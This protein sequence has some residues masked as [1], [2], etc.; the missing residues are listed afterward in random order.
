MTDMHH[1]TTTQ[2]VPVTLPGMGHTYLDQ[3]MVPKVNAFIA[4]AQAHGVSLHFNSAFRTPEHQER[5]H[6]DPNAITPATHSLHS[7]GFA[8]DMNY[9]T[10][11]E[12]QR[13][14]IRTA[15]HDAGLSWGGNFHRSDPPHFYADPPIDR[16]TAIANATRQ[17]NELTGEHR[18]PA[19]EH[20]DAPIHQHN[21]LQAPPAYP[22]PATSTQASPR[23]DEAS[24]PDHALFQQAYAGV[25]KID[26]ERGRASDQLSKNL[27]GALAVEAK[28]QGLKQIDSVLLDGDGS[29]AL[30]AEQPMRGVVTNVAN[31]DTAEAIYKPIEQSTQQ[32]A[33]VNQTLQ[34]QGQHEAQQMAQPAKQQV[35]ATQNVS[36]IG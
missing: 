25:I 16:N 31:V 7:A 17:Y 23:L 13:E 36:C 2:L 18:S 29:K 11:N 10:V 33:Q 32:I 21:A 30:A 19:P 20:N 6:H 14:I 5:L 34:Q 24:H 8:V 1:G 9:S 26:A 35:T 12:A 4:N 27:A 28:L 3:S 15:A 22:A